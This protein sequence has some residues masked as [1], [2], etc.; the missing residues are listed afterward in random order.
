MF[1]KYGY[2][3]I[4]ITAIISFLIIVLAIFLNN[5]IARISLMTIAI[6]LLAFT[7]YFFRDPERNAPKRDDVVVSPADGRVL[8]V[9]EVDGNKFINGRAN[10]VSIFMSPLNVHVNRVPI[11]GQVDFIE[12]FEGK[13]IAAFEDKASELNERNELGITNINGKI[14]FTQVAGFV[15]RRIV[16]E[17]TVGDKVKIGERFGMI[18]FGSRVDVI[19][20]SHLQLSQIFLPQ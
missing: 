5:N 15:A 13:Y 20:P 17:L 10:Q 8:F 3:T 1:T 7:L 4:G 11:T 14:F 9:K 16:N 2:T 6:L 18:K 12:Y 19:A